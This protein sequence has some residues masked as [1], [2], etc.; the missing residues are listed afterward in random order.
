ME[1]DPSSSYPTHA[2]DNTYIKTCTLFIGLAVQGRLSTSILHEKAFRLI[3]KW[4][5][6]GGHLDTSTTPPTIHPDPTGSH[7]DFKSRRLDGTRLAD[8]GIP[9]GYH[10]HPGV[11][12]GKPEYHNVETRKMEDLFH[13]DAMDWTG[14]GRPPTGILG[15]RV[16]VL[17]DAT[18]LGFRL[19]HSFSDAEGAYEILSAFASSVGGNENI[20]NTRIRP[21]KVSAELASLPV[22]SV[23]PVPKSDDEGFVQHSANDFRVGVTGFLNYIVRGLVCGISEAVFARKQPR[24]KMIR[25]PAAYV[26]ELKR[27]VQEF[28]E[29]NEFA[30]S[31]GDVISAWLLKVR[32]H[33]TAT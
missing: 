17:D 26:T 10:N 5:E 12:E 22:D 27:S 31:T 18:L 4:P 1:H 14:L 16:T 33:K 9:L 28:S 19:P 24:H 6:L 30:V 23:D 15:L 21:P 11:N 7:L 8:S 32:Y 2:L 13:F 3:S 29:M 25:L 20:P